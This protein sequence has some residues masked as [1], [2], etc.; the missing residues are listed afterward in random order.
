[1][2]RCHLCT[3]YVTTLLIWSWKNVKSLRADCR[4]SLTRQC[5]RNL[6]IPF[7][8]NVLKMILNKQNII[9]CYSIRIFYAHYYKPLMLNIIL[10]KHKPSSTY[11]NDIFKYP[12]I[13]L[14]PNVFIVNMTR[15]SSGFFPFIFFPFFLPF[16]FL[17]H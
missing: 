13:Q 2:L 16:F 3:Y 5:L 17:L 7:L 8:N 11:F 6:T 9:F 1:M 15:Y 10:M 14:C 4:V 12:W